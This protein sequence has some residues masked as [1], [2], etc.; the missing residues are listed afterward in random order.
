[1]GKRGAVRVSLLTG[2]KDPH[3]AL[4]LLSGIVNKNICIDFIGNNE[5]GKADEI[6]NN[7][8]K[9]YNL[10]GDQKAL[11]PFIEKIIRVL[12]YYWKLMKYV[13]R[14]DSPL[15]HI[16]WLNRFI[17]FDGTI[18][19]LYY[20]LLGKKLV[21]TA[22]NVNIWERDGK[23]NG[24]NRIF[25]NLLYRSM[26]HIIVHTEKM[27]AQ[28][29]EKYGVR[30]G[31]V[32]VIPFGINRIIPKSGLS[33]SEARERL[34]LKDEK[35]ILFFGNIAP[36]KGLE[37]LISGLARVRERYGDCKLI[38]GGMIKR[39]EE[40]WGSIQGL[41]DEQR[42]EP[43]VLKRIEYIPDR[44][45]EVFFK[46][47]DLLVL[48]Y[49]RIFQSG[50]LFLSYNF[51][52]PVIATDVGSLREEIIEGKTGFVCLPESPAD[53]SKKII[54]YFQSNLYKHLEENRSWIVDYANK[55]YSWDKIGEKTVQV[56][57]R[58]LADGK[59]SGNL[60]I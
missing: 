52:L 58:V 6:K 13:P 46:A 41:I 50:V 40:Y 49:R 56:Y 11:A 33:R 10:R 14:T 21:Y 53:L 23:A 3:Y 24:L 28:L 2:G 38:I 16:L 7:A 30:E 20:R 27:K 32:T 19:N 43:Y 60:C 45:V 17:Y 34:G 22:H 51:G 18:V 1:V 37:N 55:R 12:R 29:I 42:L 15:F 39:C 8:V 44:E 26:N 59:G 57:R 54:T 48:P 47:A 5:M 35:A 36:Y 25:L 4:G 9:Y 31:S